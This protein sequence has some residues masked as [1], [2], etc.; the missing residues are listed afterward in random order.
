[1]IRPTHRVL[2]LGAALALTAARGAAQSPTLPETPVGRQ[3]AALLRAV[4]NPTEASVREFVGQNMDAEFQRIPLAEHLSMFRR[5]G[6]DLIGAPI[7]SIQAS[8][9]DRLA[10]TFGAAAGSLVMD[11][12]V[13]AAPP[14]RI[15]GLGV[16]GGGAAPGEAEPAPAALDAAAQRSIVDSAAVV[17][18]G[19]YVDAD[20]GRLIGAHLK[21]RLAAGAY[22]TVTDPTA[23]SEA[24]T[25]DLR[26]VNGDRHLRARV[27]PPGGGARRRAAPSAE[28]G[29]GYRFLDSVAVLPGNVGYLKFAGIPGAREA[30]DEVAR[31]LREVERTDAVVIDLRGSPGGSAEMANFLISHFTRPG[32]LS[33]AVG[34]RMPADT[35]LRRTLDAVP[36]PRRLE[37]PLYVLI[38]NGAG[39]AAEDIPFVLRNLG[40]ATLVGERTGGAGRNNR[41][42]RLPGGMSLSV[43]ITRVWDPCTGRDWE[44]VGVEPHIVVPSAEALD[45]ALREIQAGRGRPGQVPEAACRLAATG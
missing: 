20:T 38:D 7:Q 2:L 11:I 42:F 19:F 22:R 24:L 26:A 37:V 31:A 32:L 1:M 23:F 13:E 43:S 36:G 30:F 18:A 27:G 10:V 35:T 9:P 40:R 3:A 14:H 16:R 45:A 21:Q 25:Q 44:R 4:Q 33:L 39:S 28:A 41:F 29:A 34:S 12:A 17:L 8:G 5:M 6:G 15:N